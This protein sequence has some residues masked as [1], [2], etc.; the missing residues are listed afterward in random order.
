VID[1][2]P[3]ILV[4]TQMLAKGHDF[5]NL[6]T[7]IVTDADQ[8]LS[9]ADFR[10]VEHFVQLLTQVSGRAGRHGSRGQVLVQTHRPDSEWFD[11]ILKQNYDELAAAIMAERQQFQWPPDTHLALISARASTAEAVFTALGD[12]AHA[13]RALNSPV[14]LLGPAPAPMERRN[15]QYHGQLLI[16]GKRPLLQWILKETGPWAYKKRG[17]VMFQLDVDPWDLW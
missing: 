3:C 2:D 4:G 10:S 6:S 5:K 13:I 14:R 8:G 9:G 11:R 17:K 15:R 16:L 1:G 7:V 12:V